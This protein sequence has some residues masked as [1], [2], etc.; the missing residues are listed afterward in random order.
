MAAVPACV[1][2]ITAIFIIKVP[3]EVIKYKPCFMYQIAALDSWNLNDNGYTLL[4]A[5]CEYIH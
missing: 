5:I 4:L 1:H 3:L 2:P